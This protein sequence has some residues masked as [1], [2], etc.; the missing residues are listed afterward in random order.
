MPQAPAVLLVHDDP[1]V[2]DWLTTLL[3]AAGYR[4]VIAATSFAARSRLERG[5]IAAI[6]VGWS[7]GGG[8]GEALARWAA[9][10]GAGLRERMVALVE[11]SAEAAAAQ[12]AGLRAYPAAAYQEILDFCERSA[13][14]AGGEGGVAFAAEPLS[15]TRSPRLLLVEDDMHQV[16]FIR[17]ILAG[18]GFDVTV[19][20]NSREAIAELET[21]ALDVILCDWYMD[22]GGGEELYDWLVEHEP[23]LLDRC[24][25]MTGGPTRPIRERAPA[26]TCYPKGQDSKLLISALTRA[27]R[28]AME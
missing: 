17:D 13:A 11:D 20:E 8:A 10:E 18:Y 15:L 2:L 14:S 5:S 9:E 21:G 1:D 23:D 3:E 6:L 7:V 22:G 27:A 26:A 12:D 24:V 16:R 28:R 25:F 19:A 4:V